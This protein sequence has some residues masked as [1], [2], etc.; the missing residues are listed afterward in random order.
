MRVTGSLL[1][2]AARRFGRGAVVDAVGAL[3]VGCGVGLDP[4]DREVG[5]AVDDPPA[6]LGA[7]VVHGDEE[8]AGKFALDQVAGHG[9]ASVS[10]VD[11]GPRIIEAPAAVEIGTRPQFA[12]HAYP[13][14]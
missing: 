11:S 4:G 14:C 12:S 9:L 5:V 13:D 10:P 2:S 6:Q 8:S 1:Q 3:A 7:A